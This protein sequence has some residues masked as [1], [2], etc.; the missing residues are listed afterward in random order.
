MQLIYEKK[1]GNALYQI[2][3]NQEEESFYIIAAG[4][5]DREFHTTTN[6][7]LL[8]EVEK[9]KYSRIIFNLSKQ[10]STQV[11]S[12]VWFVSF[13]TPRAY[14]ILKGKPIYAAAITSSNPMETAFTHIIMRS[15]ARFNPNIN[16]QLF[17]PDDMNKARKWIDQN[18]ESKNILMAS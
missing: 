17:N 1:Q 8:E 13:V 7:R 14:N 2:F 6:L 11:N 12:R 10:I 9:Y 16:I 15:I 4:D 5:I 3:I 18:R